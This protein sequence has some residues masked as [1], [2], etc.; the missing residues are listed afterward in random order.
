MNEYVLAQVPEYTRQFQMILYP[1]LAET[2]PFVPTD[3]ALQDPLLKE[4]LNSVHTNRGMMR[5]ILD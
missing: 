2:A 4:I 5:Y 3:I 1:G